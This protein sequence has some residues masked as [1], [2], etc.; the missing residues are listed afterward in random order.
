MKIERLKVSHIKRNIIIGVIIVFIISAIV[1]NFTR[2]RYRVTDSIEIV[3]GT[4]NYTP[5]D[6]KTLAIYIENNAEEYIYS[7][8]IPVSGYDFN[9]EKSYCTTNGE[10]DTSISM[11]YENGYISINNIN[12]KTK[13]YFYW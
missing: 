12:K 6:F 1:L 10:I 13:C 2:A 8:E 4:V 7:E 11:T 3:N 9:Q 5:Y